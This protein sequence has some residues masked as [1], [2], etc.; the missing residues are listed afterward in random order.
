MGG[1]AGV[2]VDRADGEDAVVEGGGA[3]EGDAVGA[4]AGGEDLEC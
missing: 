4:V 3:S 1:G 2:G